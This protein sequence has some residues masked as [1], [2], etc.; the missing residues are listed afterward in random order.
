[1]TTDTR[2]LWRSSSDDADD[3]DDDDDEDD[4]GPEE[5]SARST[6]AADALTHGRAPAAVTDDDAGT[7]AGSTFTPSTTGPST[8]TSVYGLPERLNDEGRASFAFMGLTAIREEHPP[9][10]GSISSGSTTM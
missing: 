6:V 9:V 10:S 7:V 1:M 4:E 2:D 3:D 5:G 8:T